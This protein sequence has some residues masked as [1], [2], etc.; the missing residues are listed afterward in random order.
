MLFV[1]MVTCC[2]NQPFSEVSKVPDKT[3]PKHLS[4]IEIIFV[5]AANLCYNC[6]RNFLFTVEE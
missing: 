5:C 6:K 3:R 4:G 1:A 2:I